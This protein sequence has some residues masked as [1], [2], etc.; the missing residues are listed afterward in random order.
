MP[1]VPSY[2]ES[3]EYFTAGLAFADIMSVSLTLGSATPT[4]ACVSGAGGGRCRASPWCLHAH[5]FPPEMKLNLPFLRTFFLTARTLLVL[6][7]DLTLEP[8]PLLFGAQAHYPTLLG[9]DSS[10]F[11]YASTSLTTHQIFVYA[12]CSTE[13]SRPN[14]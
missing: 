3:D 11:V 5:H 14:N 8:F 9:T 10:H 4:S 12:D 2:L 1:F 6:D 7:D 13:I